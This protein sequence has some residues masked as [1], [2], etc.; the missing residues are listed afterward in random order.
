[1]F[2]FLY[3]MKNLSKLPCNLLSFF[4]LLVLLATFSLPSLLYWFNLGLH[5]SLGVTILLNSFWFPPD[6]DAT[7]TRLLNSGNIIIWSMSDVKSM[8]RIFR[9]PTDERL[10]S[11]WYQSSRHVFQLLWNM[12]SGWQLS[13]SLFLFFLI[14]KQLYWHLIDISKFQNYLK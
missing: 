9:F 2:P 8:K 10:H 4:W 1:M 13:K 14:K 3:Y 11:S 6:I 5:D 7:W 12:V